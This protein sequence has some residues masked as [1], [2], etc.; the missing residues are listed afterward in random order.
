M[1]KYD[2]QNCL[3]YIIFH[4]G[5][6]SKDPRGIPQ[7]GNFQSWGLIFWVYV[8]NINAYQQH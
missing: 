6:G 4:A 7:F 8:F 2:I 5:G 1:V 3:G